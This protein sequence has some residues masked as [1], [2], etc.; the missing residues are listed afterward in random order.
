M[1]SSD[2]E[3]HTEKVWRKRPS[4][5]KR[6]KLQKQ[7]PFDILNDDAL[8]LVATNLPIQTRSTLAQVCKSAEALVTALHHGVKLGTVGRLKSVGC[9]MSQTALVERFD[10]VQPALFCP[11]RVVYR[12][13][14]YGNY[15]VHLF[16]MEIV[17]SAMARNHGWQW[18]RKLIDIKLSKKAKQLDV[19]RRAR[20]AAAKRCE[21]RP[22][23]NA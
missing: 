19:A 12:D 6:F 14:C 5:L 2:R 1:S 10:I 20:A 7:N 22:R 15:T 17:L 4:A 13:G 16:D 11:P 3:K 9:M 23:Q 21:K 8:Q 18:I